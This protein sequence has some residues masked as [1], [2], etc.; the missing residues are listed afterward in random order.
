VAELEAQEK[1]TPNTT[2]TNNARLHL[3]RKL[4][5][6]RTLAASWAHVVGL[7][8]TEHAAGDTTE[9]GAAVTASAPE[10]TVAWTNADGSPDTGIV[11]NTGLCRS[12][13]DG[14]S[15]WMP[16]RSEDL[17]DGGI[18]VRCGTDVLA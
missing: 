13:Y 12:F 16:L 1:A 11:C 2:Q 10:R 18:C 5:G 7:I 3:A 17:P 4:K 8:E 15:K 9:R 14:V 6:A